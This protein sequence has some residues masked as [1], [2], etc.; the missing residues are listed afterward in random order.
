MNWVGCAASLLALAVAMG[1]FGAHA[2]RSRLD[3]GSL[4]V[5]HTAVLYHFLHAFGMLAVSALVRS[6]GITGTDG[7]R[8]CWLLL[9]GIVLFSG[10]L[11]A[12]ALSGVRLLGAITPFGGLAFIAAWVLLAIAAF[13]SSARA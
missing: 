13:R 9:A 1:A 5:Y 12:L 7:V 4:D 3:A 10:S 2:L 6:G 11:Y 8:V